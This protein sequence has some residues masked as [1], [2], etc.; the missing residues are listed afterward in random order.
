MYGKFWN[1]LY[2]IRECAKISECLGV[3]LFLFSFLCSFKWSNKIFTKH[4]QDF[5]TDKGAV[6]QHRRNSSKSN[7]QWI[8][9]FII[10]NIRYKQFLRRTTPSVN[11]NIWLLSN[12]TGKD[13]ER[14]VDRRYSGCSVTDY[15]SS[16]V[17]GCVCVCAQIY[18][19]CKSHSQSDFR[20][21][22]ICFTVVV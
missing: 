12:V 16:F 4:V 18:W 6:K 5:T 8:I 22:T 15:W 14:C 20:A 21:E 9:T 19:L 2:V 1:T 11:K 13:L 10:Y 7:L 17:C 3:F